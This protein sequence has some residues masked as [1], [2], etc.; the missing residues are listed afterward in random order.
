MNITDD[1]YL[2]K[3]KRMG[4][5]DERIAFRMNISPAEVGRRWEN[6]LKISQDQL[7]NGLGSLCQVGLVMATQFQ[8]MGQSLG[9]LMGALNNTYRVDELQAVMDQC[10]KDMEMASWLLRN[11]II[12]KPFSLPSPQQLAEE[13]EKDAKSSQN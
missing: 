4:W 8:L 3:L 2:L 7:A 9:I 6:L 12:L 11:V 5:N 10:P 1:S 13:I